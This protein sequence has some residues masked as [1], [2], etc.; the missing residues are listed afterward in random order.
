MAKAKKPIPEGY[1]TITP[2][3]TIEGAARAIDWYKHALGAQEVGRALGP[4]G[5][6]MH[7]DGGPGSADHCPDRSCSSYRYGDCSDAGS[8]A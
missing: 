1:H 6:V 4:D 7:A 5:K 3:F 8:F 2:H